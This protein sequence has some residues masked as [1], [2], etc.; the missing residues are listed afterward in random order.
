MGIQ[1][2][3]VQGS[4]SEDFHSYFPE[5]IEYLPGG[6]DSGFKVT[7]QDIF[8]NR[9]TQVRRN[10]KRAIV[11]EEEAVALRSLNHRDAFILE[12]GRDI[13]V[14]FGDNCSP[15]LKNAANMKAE[16][17]ESASN[18][19]LT[20]KEAVDDGFWEVF[21]G[22]MLQREITA[23][24]AVGEE[25]PADFGEGVLYNV[26]VD[27]DR[28][29]TVKEVARGELDRDQL[30]TTGV[31]MVD[32]R[33]EIFLWLGKETTKLEKGSAFQTASNYLKMNGRDVDKTSIT[34]LK[35]GADSKNK[36]W[37]KMFPAKK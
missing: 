20:K 30:D 19:E 7:Q 13:Y 33:D 28:K 35:E 32:T 22:Q 27:E 2:R 1:H 21:G 26:Q 16:N 10:E 34:V 6:V 25:V 37:M 18:G 36:T 29:L 11:F 8:I 9:L 4:E 14:W 31:M 3:E 12:K 15:F 24:D 23:A 5:G 17:M